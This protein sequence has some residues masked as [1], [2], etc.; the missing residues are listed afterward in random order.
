MRVVCFCIFCEFEEKI[1][2]AI[3]SCDN[4]KAARRFLVTADRRQLINGDSWVPC[5]SR[6]DLAGRASNAFR[7]SLTLPVW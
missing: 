3:K 2:Q 6:P 5:E 7:R 4:T 1:A